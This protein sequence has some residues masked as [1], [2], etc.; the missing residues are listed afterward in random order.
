MGREVDTTSDLATVALGSSVPTMVD[1]LAT[2][3]FDES[4]AVESVIEPAPAA[5]GSTFAGYR[6]LDELGRGGMGIVYLAEDPASGARVALKTVRP[7]APGALGAIHREIHTLNRLSHPGVVRILAHGIEDGRPWYAMDL[8]EGSTLEARLHAL[9]DGGPAAAAAVAAVLG[10]LGRL[11]GTLAFLHGE[12]VVHRDVSPRN[13]VIR[14]DGTPLL[15]DFG[16]ALRDEH[17][18][19]AVLALSS[20]GGTIAYIAPEQIRGA[21]VDARADLY[22]LGCILYQTVTGRPPFLAEGVSDLAFKHLVE[23]PVPPSRLAPG[24]DRRLEDLILRLLRKR[25][26]D[27]LGYAEDVAAALAP[28]AVATLPPPRAYVYRPDLSGRAEL[29]ASFEEL[30]RGATEGRGVEVLIAGESGV[31]KT[32]FL[33]EVSARARDLGFRVVTGECVSLGPS[34]DGER[35]TALHPF[36]PLLRAIVDLCADARGRAER[37]LGPRGRVLAAYESALL[38]VPGQEA[39]PEPP[40]LAAQAARERLISA[41][42]ET[43]RRLAD[44]GPLLLVLDDLQ[45]ADELSL[46]IL[47][48]L[49]GEAFARRRFVLVGAYRGEEAT[50]ALERLARGAA[51][52]MTLARLDASAI[53]GM[54]A[55]MLAL[56]RVPPSLLDRLSAAAVGNP[57]FVAEY[58]RAAVEERWIVRDAGARWRLADEVPKLPGSMRELLDLRLT[59]LSAAAR[60]LVDAAA[61]LGRELSAE[62]LVAV[63]ELSEPEGLT[64]IAEVVARAM[65]EELPGDRFRFVH[66][67]LRETAYA[68]LPAPARRALHGKA[69]A[70]LAT[71]PGDAARLSFHALLA[72]HHAH[73]GQIAE[74]L[75]HLEFAGEEALARAAHAEAAGI[76]QRAIEIHRRE[77]SPAALAGAERVARWER[78][79]GEAYYALGDLQR[80][81]EH[82]ARALV[83]LG[84][85]LPRS[86]AGLV[87]ELFA[88]IGRQAKHL[89]RPRRDVARSPDARTRLKEAALA[90]S[91]VGYS[92]YFQEDGLGLMTA[93]LL[94]VNLAERADTEGLVT[95]P[96]AQLGYIA[97]VCQL[98]PLAKTYF[99][100]AKS[101][102]EAAGDPR[103]VAVALVH[104]ALYDA[105]AG[106]LAKAEELCELGIARLAAARDPQEDEGMRIILA[107]VELA[108][109]QYEASIRRGAEL[110]AS[111]RAR[112]NRQ[113]EAFGLFAIARGSIRLGRLDA[114]LD[115]LAEARRLLTAHLSDQV[116]ASIC[117]G[118]TASAHLARGELAEAE[119]HADA[120]M[121]AIRR[122]R[123]SPFS[124]A[125]GHDGAAAVYLE[126]WRRAR[127]GHVAS[128]AAHAAEAGAGLRRFAAL[129][130]LGRPRW[131]LHQGT[132]E[133]LRGRRLSAGLAFRAARDRALRLGMPYEAA[134]AERCLGEHVAASAE[135]RRAHFSRAASEFEAIGCVHEAAATRALH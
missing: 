121:D 82:A 54:V 34:Q 116:S 32:R 84:H 131:L 91:R 48:R 134:L 68:S 83:G 20:V 38:A 49:H 86:R 36:R 88:Q 103:D 50:A 62:V 130:A 94:A 101:G 28:A 102:A 11:A 129:F 117:A 14:S 105:G 128:F 65:L 89:A 15:V 63:A 110:L 85:P 2:T 57:F 93:A 8:I 16:L 106:R 76:Y 33:A 123:P 5:L 73:A 135:D 119:R 64:A 47:A 111:A 27:R 23:E 58:V 40:P 60:R 24:V 74:A 95:L 19:R 7:R 3:H 132:V 113:H 55:S 99:A 37:V 109:G 30:L 112:S 18:G 90:A 29:L 71:R 35:A 42:E 122:A 108:R 61:V 81:E 45:W 114:A 125:D 75:H 59:R 4:S 17:R 92:R 51:T 43:I 66:D 70:A 72:H 96:Y 1:G 104:E 10:V 53:E 69:A 79:L 44:E 80:M 98:G 9:H 46:E 100:R 120:A 41:L 127:G 67:K 52:T 22:A 21:L 26:R 77:G 97:G 78:R 87:R 12:G 25:P 39:Y 31:G 118:L 115:H 133:A 107:H 126:L 13:V 6:L 56:D 124:P